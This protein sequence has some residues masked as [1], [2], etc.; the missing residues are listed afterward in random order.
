[1]FMEGVIYSHPFYFNMESKKYFLR[2]EYGIQRLL[3]NTWC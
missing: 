1:M 3:Q 2:L